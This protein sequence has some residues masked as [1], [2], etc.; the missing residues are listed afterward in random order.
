MT[1]HFDD[2]TEKGNMFSGSGGLLWHLGKLQRPWR[3]FFGG[4]CLGGAGQRTAGASQGSLGQP[5]P[6]WGDERRYIIHIA[7]VSSLQDFFLVKFLRVQIYWS[8]PW[9][10]YFHFQEIRADVF[11]ILLRKWELCELFF[12]NACILY[13]CMQLNGFIN[14]FIPHL[15]DLRR[16][17]VHDRPSEPRKAIF[18]E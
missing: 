1:I 16:R 7:E 12:V 13:V 6:R 15:G 10:N 18:R 11:Y 17:T 2:S 14:L 9:V 3:E 8:A 5:L 4:R